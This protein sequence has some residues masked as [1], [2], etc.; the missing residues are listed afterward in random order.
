MIQA[1]F[2]AAN[3]FFCGLNVGLI[4]SGG[5]PHPLLTSLVSFISFSVM[6][7]CFWG[8]SFEIKGTLQ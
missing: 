5:T 7:L 1:I 3:A 2:I 6:L 8:L 4:L